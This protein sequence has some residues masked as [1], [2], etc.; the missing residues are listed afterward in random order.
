MGQEFWPFWLQFGLAIIVN[1]GV[2]LLAYHPKDHTRKK[3]FWQYTFVLTAF[4]MASAALAL[5]QTWTTRDDGQHVLWGRWALSA[6]T[7]PFVM[8]VMTLSMTRSTLLR[9]AV[10]GV[11]LLHALSTLFMAITPS[12]NGGNA[13]N[14][15]IL[16][17][18]FS[19]FFAVVELVLSVA[20]AMGWMAR[21]ENFEAKLAGKSVSREKNDGGEPQ[22]YGRLYN[23]WTLSLMCV[24]GFVCLCLYPTILA[25][26][27]EGYRVSGISYWDTLWLQMCICNVI[28]VF[29]FAPIVYFFVN[30][31]GSMAIYPARALDPAQ[32]DDPSVELLAPNPSSPL[33]AQIQNGNLYYSAPVPVGNQMMMPMGVPMP[34]PHQP[35]YGYAHHH[36][37]PPVQPAQPHHHMPMTVNI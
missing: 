29:L 20:I 37:Q 34:P 32:S 19:Y 25:I 36:Q 6:V 9:R 33:E 5:G 3:K 8:G 15:L 11:T 16:W 12:R 27:P 23:R 31:D 18:T 14:S 10:M 17:T 7:A 28:F 24:V 21:F 26:S 4:V 35:Y 2:L 1:I 30:H 22:G 13:Y